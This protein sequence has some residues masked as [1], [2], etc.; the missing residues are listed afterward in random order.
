MKIGKSLQWGGDHV[1]KY[2]ENNDGRT[3]EY[4]NEY[5]T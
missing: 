5:G 1:K 2:A 3:D 4:Y